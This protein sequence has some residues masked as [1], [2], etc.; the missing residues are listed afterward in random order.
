MSLTVC[1]QK[2]MTRGLWFFDE[3]ECSRIRNHLERVVSD[4]K[5]EAGSFV[6]STVITNEMVT[7]LLRRIINHFSKEEMDTR[8]PF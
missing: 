7:S 8:P 1:S 2:V 3:G 6:P 4:I 5:M